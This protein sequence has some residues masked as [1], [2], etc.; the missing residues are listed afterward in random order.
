MCLKTGEFNKTERHRPDEGIAPKDQSPDSEILLDEDVNEILDQAIME[1]VSPALHAD[2]ITK[3]LFVIQGAN[4]PRVNIREADQI[5][6]AMRAKKLPVTYVVY[7]D[8][9]HGF[10]RPDNRL[11][12]YGRVDEFLA[13]HLGGRCEPWQKIEGSSADVR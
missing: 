6:A 8:E 5:V 4:D 12:F 9:G 2:K 13:E 1:K 10:A 3:P 11:D 7:T